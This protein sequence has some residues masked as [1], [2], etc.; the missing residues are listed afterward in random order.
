M[1]RFV[2]QNEIILIAI[3]TFVI[4]STVEALGGDTEW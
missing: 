2:I 4:D 1:V 3:S